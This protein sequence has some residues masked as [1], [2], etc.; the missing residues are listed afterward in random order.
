M[1]IIALILITLTAA[2]WLTVFLYLFTT[3]EIQDGEGF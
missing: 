3:D 2:L 1:T